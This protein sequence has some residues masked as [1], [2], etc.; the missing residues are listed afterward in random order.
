MRKTAKLFHSGGSLAVRIP[1]SWIGDADRVTLTTNGSAIIITPDNR[2]LLEL[3]RHFRKDGPIDFD[4]PAQ[5]KTP[6]SR[7]L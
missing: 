2:N 7:S 5:P 4:R 6:E 3:A 1:K